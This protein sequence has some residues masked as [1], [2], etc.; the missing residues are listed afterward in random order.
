MEKLEAAVSTTAISLY[1]YSTQN[2][3]PSLINGVVDIP[4][5][6]LFKR[7]SAFISPFFLRHGWT[8]FKLSKLEPR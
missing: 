2:V 5:R 3:S 7:D 1:K 8:R 4:I 6:Q